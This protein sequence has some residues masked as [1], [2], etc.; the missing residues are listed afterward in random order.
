[1]GKYNIWSG[2]E[3]EILE[4]NYGILTYKQIAELIYKETKIERT[5][6]AVRTRASLLNIAKLENY[7]WSKE[8][9]EYLI[10]NYKC[11]TYK[12]IAE[13][14]NRSEHAIYM[15]VDK[16][17]LEKKKERWTETE[18]DNL[19]NNIFSTKRSYN[20]NHTKKTNMKKEIKI[21]KR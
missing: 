11:E 20:C 17:G 14:L 18:I 6:S 9:D 8:E 7:E 19:K 3:D 5:P 15:R 13:V 21:H 2:R 16:L 12:V 4:E 1:M 10:A